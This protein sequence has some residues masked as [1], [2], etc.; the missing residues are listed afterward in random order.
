MKVYALRTCRG[1]WAV[2]S[3]DGKLLHFES[4]H[5]AIGAARSPASISNP[6]VAVQST[7]CDRTFNQRS[8]SEC[9]G[10]Q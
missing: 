8:S 7:E 9:T 6:D 5:E 3:D 4:Y 2:C 10:P 1:Q